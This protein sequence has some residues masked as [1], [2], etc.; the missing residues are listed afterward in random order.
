[1]SERLTGERLASMMLIR[2]GR[3]DRDLGTAR[4]I[5]RDL[6]QFEKEI[7]EHDAEIVLMDKVLALFHLL[8]EQVQTEFAA[9]IERVVS[10]GLLAVFDEAIQFKIN[11]KVRG[12]NVNVDFRLINENGTET[13]LLDARGGGVVAVTCS[14]LQMVFVRLLDVEKVVFLDEPFAHL[15]AEYVPAMAQLLQKMSRD[16]GIQV[17]LVTHQDEFLEHADKAYRI[18]KHGDAATATVV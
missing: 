16:L 17:V 15:S 8:T 1:M 5:N 14:I 11:T 6:R 18:E 12:N 9:G 13:D 7:K 2:K 10:A 4:Q 3:F